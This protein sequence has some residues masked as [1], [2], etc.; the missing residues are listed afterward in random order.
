M[1]Y[2]AVNRYFQRYGELTSKEATIQFSVHM[3]VV[4]A[5]MHWTLRE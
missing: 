4:R 2:T 1:C 3:T 5:D